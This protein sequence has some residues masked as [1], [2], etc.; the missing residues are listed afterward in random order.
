MQT[1]LII[2]GTRTFHD[3]GFLLS[4]LNGIFVRR[5]ELLSDLVV[6]SGGASGADSLGELFA[7]RNGIPVEKFPADWALYKK[8][9]GPI[10][11]RKMADFAS[12][13]GSFGMLAAFWDGKS[14]GTKDMIRQAKEAGIETHV[15][16]YLEK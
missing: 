6:V 13:D 12:Q 2:A 10:R 14:R 8:A 16:M 7:E 4:C 15:F 5:K 1:R 9:A 11:N 3:Y